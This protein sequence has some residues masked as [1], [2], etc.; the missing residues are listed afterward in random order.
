MKICIFYHDYGEETL[1]CRRPD[2]GNP[3]LGGTQYCFL[4]LMYFYPQMNPDDELTVFRL[5]REKTGSI[6]PEFDNLKIVECDSLDYFASQCNR[7]DVVLINFS[8]ALEFLKKTNDPKIKLIVWVHNWIRGEILK[9]LAS[10]PIVKRVIFL[11]QEHYERYIDDPIIKKAD[12]VENMYY[13]G[14]KS[15]RRESYNVVF[16]GGLIPAKGFHYLAKSWKHIIYKVPEA[17]LFVVGGQRIYGGHKKL[18]PLQIAE[19]NY[20]KYFYKYLTDRKKNLLSSVHFLGVLGKEKDTIY[21]ESAVGIINPTGKTE[22]CPL[23]A[24][25]MERFSIPVISKKTNGLPD[26]VIN[27][28][29]GILF[30]T[31]LGFEHAIVKMLK[32]KKLN[33]K[34]G[35]AGFNFGNEKFSPHIITKKWKSVFANVNS[36]NDAGSY[37]FKG[38]NSNNFKWVRKISVVIHRI[39]IFRNIPSTIQV[40]DLFFKS[41]RRKKGK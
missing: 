39:P 18:G 27:K 26:V 32:N 4:M 5:K 12:V 11:G 24:I 14:K 29:T 8:F 41:V 21:N 3:G 40:E 22:V 20:E 17:N 36:G 30:K 35:D 28:V 31:R 33:Q 34:Y 15:S 23:S 7:F 1:D 38:N 13:F 9:T 16:T 10:N 6:L 37:K 2:L 19:E 25:E